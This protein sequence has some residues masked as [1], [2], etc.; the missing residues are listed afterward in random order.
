MEIDEI[1]KKLKQDLIKK[2]GSVEKAAKETRVPKSTLRDYLNGKT[3]YMKMGTA[4]KLYETTNLEYLSEILQS[5]KKLG[6]ERKEK[7][8]QLEMQIKN[9]ETSL[10]NIRKVLT[11]SNLE[12]VRAI[13]RESLILSDEKRARR[14]ADLLYAF[15]EEAKGMASLDNARKKFIELFPEKDA[16]Y[17]L[18]LINFLYNP[19]KF[20]EWVGEASYPLRK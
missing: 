9:A 11:N 17:L 19:D 7:V 8:N 10:E 16:G 1:R 15:L 6:K 12:E 3:N 20:K 4:K 5:S 18:S 14:A 2:Y 13:A